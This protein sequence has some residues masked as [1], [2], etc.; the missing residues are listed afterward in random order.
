MNISNASLF[1]STT[2]Q[3]SF[4]MLRKGSV[5][6]DG[7]GLVQVYLISECL[8]YSGCEWA[9]PPPNNNTVKINKTNSKEQDSLIK[10]IKEKNQVN[11]FKEVVYI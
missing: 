10:D 9:K 7:K 11:Y 6:V 4:H 8:T 1:T 2:A 3:Y 5:N